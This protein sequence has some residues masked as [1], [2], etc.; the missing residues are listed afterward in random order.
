[1]KH[2]ADNEIRVWFGVPYNARVQVEVDCVHQI[3]YLS[4]LDVTLEIRTPH[5]SILHK[6]P[7]CAGE[8]PAPF[9]GKDQMHFVLSVWKFRPVTDRVEGVKVADPKT[10]L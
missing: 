5:W 6:G 8:G 1:M 3:W 10:H 9:H 4:R 2:D 7:D